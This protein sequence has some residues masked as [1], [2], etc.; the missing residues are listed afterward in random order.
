MSHRVTRQGASA[1]P[2][3]HPQLPWTRD[4]LRAKPST[5]HRSQVVGTPPAGETVRY[6]FLRQRCGSRSPSP[7]GNDALCD[8]LRPRVVTP[9]ALGAYH[10]DRA[11][12]VRGNH[13]DAGPVE[14]QPRPGAVDS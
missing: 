3:S 9:G 8:R 1:N 13:V 12:M 14:R 11:S 2:S 10:S 6:Q 5:A 4:V 7:G